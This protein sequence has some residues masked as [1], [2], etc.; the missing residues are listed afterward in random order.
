MAPTSKTT[1]ALPP[2]MTDE[3]EQRVLAVVSATKKLPEV[4]VTAD[5]TLEELGIDSLDRL[6]ILFDLEGAFDISINDEEARGVT[7]VGEMIGGVRQLLA[8]RGA[9]TES[10]DGTSSAQ[11][12]EK[13]GTA[14]RSVPGPVR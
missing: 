12:G 10:T 11:A 1:D 14:D 5:S 6:N 2:E 9:A 13:D 8:A 3:V 4:Q 7:T